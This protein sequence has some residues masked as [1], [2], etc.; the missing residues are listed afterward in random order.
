[1]TLTYFLRS[2]D[3]ILNFHFPDDNS[4]INLQK[5]RAY[6][7]DMLEQLINGFGRQ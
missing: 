5:V 6:I 3:V 1:M 7:F 4:I 2:N